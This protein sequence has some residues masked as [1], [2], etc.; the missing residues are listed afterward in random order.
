MAIYVEVLVRGSI[1][2]LWE[3]T[4][5]PDLHERWDLRFSEIEYL[6]RLND[7]DPQRFLYS[8]R[9]GFGLMIKGEGES[10]GTIEQEGGRRTSSLKFSSAD[11]KSL[12]SEGSGYWKYVPTESGIRFLTWYDYRTRFGLFGMAVDSVLFRPMI[13]W[14][15]AWSF[16]ALRLWIEKGI[17]PEKT[18]Q[19]AVIY[20]LARL[21]VAFVWLYQGMVPKL[22]FNAPG[23][24][25]LMQLSGV[26]LPQLSI[27]V[28]ILGCLEMAMGSAMLICWT[29]KHLFSVTAA[30][31]VIA[32]GTVV[33]ASP[34]ELAAAFNPVTLNISVFAL[35][36][37]GLIAGKNL[38]SASHC[39]RTKPEEDN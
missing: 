7:A 39:L 36:L 16:D 32:L 10:L 6:P 30:L 12:I 31:M 4:Q 22:I 1:E 27:A 24:S 21:A 15:T 34:A 3:K 13:G 37:I 23:E 5:T 17:S 2:E 14:A 38:A 19:N 25:H 35:S 29:S 26:P 20:A 18:F 33:L 9:I 8:T 28:T 11:P